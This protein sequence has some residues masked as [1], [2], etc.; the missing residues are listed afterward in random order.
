TYLASRK[1]FKKITDGEKLDEISKKYSLPK[2]FV[3]YVGDVNYNK[4]LYSL[5]KASKEIKI[6]LV[7][8]GKQAK[9][10]KFDRN[11]IENKPLVKLLDK[12]GNNKD[13]KRL[14][15]VEDS[16]LIYIY[17]LATVYC[18]P[19]FYEGFGLP[20]LEAFSSG[21]PVVAS[22][23]QAHVEIA[24]D[25][26]VYMDPQDYK[27]IASKISKVLESETSRKDLI[28]KGYEKLKDYSWEK[29][30]QQT[31]KIYKNLI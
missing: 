29:T 15:F 10:E 14:G 26:V 30:A 23:I 17:N 2:K 20:I 8:V 31:F 3:L 4:N 27:D 12:F 5:A 28:K 16:D 7:I 11:H 1:I 21:V 13:I 25:A 19:S 18:Q 6:P 24:G 22:K 9:E